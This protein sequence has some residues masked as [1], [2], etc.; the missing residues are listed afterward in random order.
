MSGAA[1][2][3]PHGTNPLEEPLLPSPR[4]LSDSSA[5]Y[6]N[7]T[8]LPQIPLPA[9]APTN[10]HA[11]TS[12]LEELYLDPSL[13]PE[14]NAKSRENIATRVTTTESLLRSKKI[15]MIGA[16]LIVGLGIAII[17]CSILGVKLPIIGTSFTISLGISLIYGGAYLF[18]IL[19]QG[20]LALELEAT[21]DKLQAFCRQLEKT[22]RESIDNYK[23]RIT[24]SVIPKELMAQTSAYQEVQKSLKQAKENA[25]DLQKKHSELVNKK[26][27]L[28]ARKDFTQEQTTLIREVEGSIERATILLEAAEEELSEAYLLSASSV[29]LTELKRVIQEQ[30]GRMHHKQALRQ[31]I[32]ERQ[33]SLF[34][35]MKNYIEN[36]SIAKKVMFG[37]AATTLI[38]AGVGIG[39]L[40]GGTTFLMIFGPLS[41]SSLLTLASY[42]YYFYAEGATISAIKRVK[43]SI[44]ETEEK[45]TDLEQNQTTINTLDNKIYE[46]SLLELNTRIAEKKEIM[47]GKIKALNTSLNTQRETLRLEMS[48]LDQAFQVAPGSVQR[49]LKFLANGVR[50]LFFS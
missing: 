10:R 26:Q 15:K 43:N 17:V 30:E 42:S 41:I 28:L 11:S 5:S 18:N 46:I 22:Q 7:A 20:S 44:Q 12:N 47:E 37:C 27:Q 23:N 4:L 1:K 48:K 19:K 40:A 14:D 35:K 6:A 24:Q 2:I 25:Q 13:I 16:L 32:E 34:S 36:A 50:G 29:T 9:Q 3:P 38:I 39:F 31:Q 21:S 33:I 8:L 49:S 45:I